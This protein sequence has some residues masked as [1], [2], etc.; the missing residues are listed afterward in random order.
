MSK[1]LMESVQ[2]KI[3]K[4]RNEKTMD[5]KFQAAP[6]FG[7]MC[8]AVFGK[9]ADKVLASGGPMAKARERLS[10]D[11]GITDITSLRVLSASDRSPVLRNE[12]S[13]YLNFVESQSRSPRI[14]DTRYAIRERRISGSAAT[15]FNPDGEL[16]AVRQSSRTQRQNT[17]S[18][19]G[20]TS[21]VSFWADAI[22]S[23]QEDVNI[24]S[25]EID[26]IIVLI[27]KKMSEMLLSN[28]EQVAEGPLSVPQ[29]GGMINRS[30][31]NNIAVSGGNLTETYVQQAI[32]A[33]RLA[34]GSGKQHCLWVPGS[35][36]PVLENIMI[37]RQPGNTATTIFER[38]QLAARMI[39]FSVPWDMVYQPRP[40]KPLPVVFDD[41]LPSGTGLLFTYERDLYPRMPKFQMF[42]NFGP[43]IL[44]RPNATLYELVLVF[45]M[46]TLDD[47]IVESRAVFTGLS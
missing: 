37:T 12:D 21:K 9:S 38:Q 34:M 2:D 8:E 39:D 7:E 1:V 10:K 4:S 35:Q 40:G 20:N 42:G 18:C 22:A 45:D 24:K 11:L 44:V 14:M 3:L 27:R 31:L 19:V 28:V 25:E 26:D 6:K 46:F 36:I 43:W 47:P 17:I 30:T 41:Q 33:I 13:K 16:P 29:N 15:P 32:N 23:Q 5:A